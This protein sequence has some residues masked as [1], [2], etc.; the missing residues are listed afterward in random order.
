MSKMR[1]HLQGDG[2]AVDHAVKTEAD[3]DA[4]DDGRDES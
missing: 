3:V 1:Q 4:V 2:A